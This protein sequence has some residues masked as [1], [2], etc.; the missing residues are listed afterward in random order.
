M[1]NNFS[2]NDFIYRKHALQ[3]RVSLGLGVPILDELPA[4]KISAAQFFFIPPD[5]HISYYKSNL[6]YCI[7]CYASFH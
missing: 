1:K 6:N 5:K 7:Q 2:F 4:A 3:M